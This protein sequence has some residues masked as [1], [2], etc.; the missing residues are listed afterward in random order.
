MD[1]K[2]LHRQG[3]SVRRIA[4]VT[5]MSRRTVRRILSQVAPK[6]YGPR[7]PRPSILD[8]FVPRLEE[9][10]AARPHARATVLH[11]AIVRE[12]YEGHYERVK[13][14]VRERRRAETARRRACV[15]FETAPGVEGQFD[16]KG[17]ARGLIASDP[18]LD[19]YFFRF[20]LA[21]SRARW[22]L[23][24]LSLKLPAV[25]ASL[26]WALE[27]VGGVPNRFVLDNPKTAVLRPRPHLELH[28]IFAD[29]CRHYGCE[30]DPAWPYHPERKGKTERSFRDIVDAG[31]LDRTYSSLSELQAGVTAVDQ[32]C[33][34]RVHGTT[35]E[36]P[37]VRL[38]REKEVL[39]GLPDVPFDPRVPETRRVLSDCTV[40]FQGAFYSVP[41]VHVGSRVVVKA[42]PL[43]S[44]IEIFTGVELVAQ[45]QQV[46]NGERSIV[47]EHVAAL[48]RPRFERIQARTA[49]AKP[50]TERR[51]ADVASLVP[52]PSIEVDHRPIEHY[53]RLLGGVR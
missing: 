29:F 26:R 10:L 5:G 45:H 3:A 51:Q 18:A 15:R 40:S 11:E 21:W 37:A 34:G 48:R 1:V 50:R 2:L 25:L 52:W 39:L 23:V 42:D 17:P 41:Y 27:Q 49:T 4:R 12:G 31:V 35:G 28:P 7:R 9:L 20:L 53:A 38:V 30:P 36:V 47:E 13:R 6:P 16:W 32:A 33:M 46:K 43:D 22:T 8:P 14:W 19:V 44:A 24:V